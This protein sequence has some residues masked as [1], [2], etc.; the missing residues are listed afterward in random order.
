MAGF[1]AFFK[2]ELLAEIFLAVGYLAAGLLAA[3]FLGSAFLTTLMD[4]E[5]S[6]PLVEQKTF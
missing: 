1:L 5:A 6:V 2:V 4:P 3:F